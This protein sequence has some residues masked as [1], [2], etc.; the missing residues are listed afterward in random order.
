MWVGIASVFVL[1]GIGVMVYMLNQAY[2]GHF[3]K[4]WPQAN[5]H[6][7]SGKIEIYSDESTY[8]RPEIEYTF[9]VKGEKYSGENIGLIM[10]GYNTEK[11]AQNILDTY[12][13]GKQVTVYY[14]PQDPN[15]SLL[16][17]GVPGDAW[18]FAGFGLF[19]AL[20]GGVFV[21]I[22]IFKIGKMESRVK[23]MEA[24]QR[25]ALYGDTGKED[26]KFLED[27]EV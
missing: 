5:G 22:G 13:I 9:T 12:S 26:E 8:Y 11:E 24:A 18:L 4:G 16:E 17:P 15:M 3:S 1:V 20:M 14:D 21:M 2:I 19:F 6:I 10:Q 23:A 27:N 7:R 25:K